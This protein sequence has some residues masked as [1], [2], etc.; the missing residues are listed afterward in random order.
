MFLKDAQTLG[1]ESGYQRVLGSSLGDSKAEPGLIQQVGLRMIR[2]SCVPDLGRH[3][4]ISCS[5]FCFF[6][7]WFFFWVG[8]GVSEFYSHLVNENGNACSA[9]L[10]DLQ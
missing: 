5:L 6:T 10:S 1:V 3:P 9:F 2:A 4:S 8:G 7:V